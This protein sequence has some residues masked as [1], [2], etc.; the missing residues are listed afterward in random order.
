MKKLFVALFF[1]S[2]CSDLFLDQ[3]EQLHPISRSSGLD[4]L[5]LDASAL[6]GEYVQA[7]GSTRTVQDLLSFT[8]IAAAG[9]TVAGAVGTVGDV[10]LAHRAIVG[11]AAQ[12]SGLR[13][14]PKAAILAIYNGAKR[15]NCISTV[16]GIGVAL[17]LQ[18]QEL[19]A[20]QIATFGAIEHVKILTHEGIVREVADYS[21]LFGEFTSG[22]ESGLEP[23]S[24]FGPESVARSSLALS[25]YLK[26]LAKCTNEATVGTPGDIPL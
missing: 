8:V 15:L 24:D 1:V 3:A 26:L 12:Q 13:L 19:S 5:A 21:D 7:A 22:V 4:E 6:A 18:G 25:Q 9:A 16:A 2:G 10:A 17:G 11:V 20:G 14:A 23:L